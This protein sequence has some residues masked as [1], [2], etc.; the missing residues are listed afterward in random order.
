MYMI[1]NHFRASSSSTTG[2]SVQDVKWWRRRRRRRFGVGLAVNYDSWKVEKI[3]S[4]YFYRE[5]FVEVP[6][7]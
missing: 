4:S 1:W 7:I 2:Y 5:D 6:L 3:A